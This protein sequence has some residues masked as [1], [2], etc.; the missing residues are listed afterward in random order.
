MVKSMLTIKNRV[1]SFSSS[2]Q[3]Q[4]DGNPPQYGDIYSAGWNVSPENYL[5]LGDTD[6]FWGCAQDD[7]FKVYS[8]QY[9]D[10]CIQVKMK[11]YEVSPSC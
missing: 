5:A 10:F 4:F 11:L 1:G 3:F 8:S 6:V 2:T 7:T 9:Y